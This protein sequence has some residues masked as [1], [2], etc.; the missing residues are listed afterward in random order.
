VK[1]L[2]ALAL[3]VC[4]GLIVLFT[5]SCVVADTYYLVKPE[6]KPSDKQVAKAYNMTELQKSTAADV[7]P[8]LYT[9]QATTELLSQSTKVLAV[10]G[11][12]NDGYKMWFTLI[13]FDE[14]DLLAK[15]KY[16]MIENEKAKILFT[17]PWEGMRFDC[18]MILEGD[19]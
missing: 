6:G 16:L 15:R 12:K 14:N 8:L 19:I 1:R 3:I 18:Q 4:L 7:L 2:K 11:E 9:P 17:E 13:A 10:Q 5:V